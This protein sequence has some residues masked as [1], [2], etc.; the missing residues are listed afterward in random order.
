MRLDLFRERSVQEEMKHRLLHDFTREEI[1]LAFDQADT[2]QK[3]HLRVEELKNAIGYLNLHLP[4]RR[5][6][7]SKNGMCR[8]TFIDSSS[9]S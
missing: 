7:E 8:M 6:L 9:S 3:G 5:I 1:K 2:Q 4:N